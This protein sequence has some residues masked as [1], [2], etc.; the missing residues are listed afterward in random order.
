M[1]QSTVPVDFS[2]AAAA[3]K[4][5]QQS[6]AEDRYLSDPHARVHRVFTGS[7]HSYQRWQRD[8]PRD[9]CVTVAQVRTG[10]SLPSPYRAPGLGHLSALPR[11][12][13]DGRTSGVPM[14]GP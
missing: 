2:S 13:Q 5:H 6:I 3:L 7:E 9:Q 8:W 12:R 4:R 11:R 10:S 14:S 1:P